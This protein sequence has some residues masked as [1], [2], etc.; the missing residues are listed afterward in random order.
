MHDVA[1]IT[2]RTKYG[3]KHMWNQIIY[4]KIWMKK[5][6]DDMHSVK[7][8]CKIHEH[9]YIIIVGE[10]V[11]NTYIFATSTMPS[12]Q[13]SSESFNFSISLKDSIWKV[14]IRTILMTK[15]VQIEAKANVGCSTVATNKTS[16]P[17]TDRQLQNWQACSVEVDLKWLLRVLI[18]Q[19]LICISY[20]A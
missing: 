10:R 1:G 11:F 9:N 13:V 20:M 5:T 3:I 8:K 19:V 16:D 4:R 7:T 17:H 12:R 6:V 2:T 14:G 15:M 18:K